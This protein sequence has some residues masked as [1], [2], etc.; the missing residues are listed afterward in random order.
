MKRPTSSRDSRPSE[1]DAARAALRAAGL[2]GTPSRVAVLRLVRTTLGPVSHA[3]VV[4]GLASARVAVDRATVYR[5][6]LDLAGRGLL[7]RI[8][9]GDHVWRFESRDVEHEP[10]VPH[11][12]FVCTGCGEVACLPGV[13]IQLTGGASAPRAV[14]TKRVGVQLTGRCNQCADRE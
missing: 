10:S 5:N 14:Q 12:H 2:R 13:G 9:L 3:E 8:D 11:A 1:E 4:R 6:L 7:R